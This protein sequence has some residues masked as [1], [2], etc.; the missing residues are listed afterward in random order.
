MRPFR[1]H[2]DGRFR[3]EELR[4]VGARVVFEAGALLFHPGSIEIADDVYVGHYAILHGYHDGPGLRVGA[5]TWIGPQCYLHAAGGITIGE[6][7]GI[8]A[9]AK[10]LTSR[11]AEPGREQPIMAGAIER[12]PVVLEAGCDV[13]IGAIVL[14]GVTIGRGAQV[15]AGAVVAADVPAFAVV[16]GVPA[17][18]L[19]ERAP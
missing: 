14:P 3:R 13:G 4:R 7:V 1:S 2:G 15:G 16:A 17:R 11:H 8:G 6:D 18:I 12:A 9:G 10:I 19:R 5:G